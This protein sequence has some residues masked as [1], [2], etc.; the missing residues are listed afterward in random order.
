M[1]GIVR[2]VF[3]GFHVKY[4]PSDILKSMTKTLSKMFFQVRLVRVVKNAHG[5]D[6]QNMFQ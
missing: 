3:V 4:C 6:A 5:S 1:N 2:M